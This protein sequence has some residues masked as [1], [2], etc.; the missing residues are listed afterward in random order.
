MKR[1]CESLAFVTAL[2]PKSVSA[3]TDTTSGY[4]DASGAGSWQ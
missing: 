3:S 4:V 1:I 2:A